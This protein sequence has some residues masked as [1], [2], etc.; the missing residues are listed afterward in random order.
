MTGEAFNQSTG[1][2]VNPT[3]IWHWSVGDQLW[4]A[5][6]DQQAYYGAVK[7]AGTIE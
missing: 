5:V 2:A 6:T 3:E 1:F 4:A 7:Q